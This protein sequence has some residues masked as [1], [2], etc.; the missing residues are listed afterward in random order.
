MLS[1]TS[2]ASQRKIWPL[3]ARHWNSRWSDVSHGEGFRPV[4]FC[5]DIAVRVNDRGFAA[6]DDP[7]F[8]ADPVTHGDI[9]PILESGGAEFALEQIL[10]LVDG[11]SGMDHDQPGPAKDAGSRAFRK[12]PVEADY[13]ADRRGHSA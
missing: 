10:R 9:D 3:C 6:V 8:P 7:V 2:R 5:Q 4:G 13:N 1:R 11:V 12:M